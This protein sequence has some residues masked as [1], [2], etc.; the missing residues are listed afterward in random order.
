MVAQSHVGAAEKHHPT[1]TANLSLKHLLRSASGGVSDPESARAPCTSSPVNEALLWEIT[2]FSP[3]LGAAPDL[4]RNT[5]RRSAKISVTTIQT[6]STR[7]DSMPLRWKTDVARMSS[8]VQKEKLA[9]R[10]AGVMMEDE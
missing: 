5:V 7:L 2:A 9:F 1:K 6:A 10:K 8:G 4:G 3:Q